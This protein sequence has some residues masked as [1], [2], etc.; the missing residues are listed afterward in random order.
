MK[1]SVR[2][3]CLYGI[4]NRVL[5]IFLSLVYCVLHTLYTSKITSSIHVF[6]CM[7]FQGGGGWTF[8]SA[9]WDFSTHK[10]SPLSP[11]PLCPHSHEIFPRHLDASIF[12][13]IFPTQTH[14]HTKIKIP[15]SGT[16]DTKPWSFFLEVKTGK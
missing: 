8:I 12:L 15:H 1:I 13:P 16:L 10:N 14:T 4:Y 11:T 9:A 5:C 6:A 3:N 7:V 2:I